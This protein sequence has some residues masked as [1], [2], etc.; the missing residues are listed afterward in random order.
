MKRIWRWLIGILF[1]LLIL[2][3]IAPFLFKDRIQQIVIDTANAN[4]N[5]D[6]YVE[7]I[8]LSFLS[9]FPNAHVSLENYRI[10][11]VAPFEKD[12]LM[13]GRQL[14]LVVNV[15]SVVRGESIEIKKIVVKAPRV[16][17]IMLADGTANWDIALADSSAVDTTTTEG[18]EYRLDLKSYEIQNAYIKYDDELLPMQM[19]IVDLTHSGGGAVTTSEYDLDTR[20]LIDKITVDY[21]GVAYLSQA[22]IE[23]D[24]DMH[25]VMGDEI[26]V[27][28]MDN[29]IKVNDLSLRADGE[30]AVGEE[31]IR[32]NLTYGA[33]EEA[34][35]KSIYSLI[36]GVYTEEYQEVDAEGDLTFEGSVNGVYNESQIPGFSLDLQVEDGQIQYPD[37][38]EAISAIQMDLHVQNPDG[39]LEKTEINLNNFQANIGADPI[40]ANAMIKGLENIFVK[41]EMEGTLDL[42][43]LAQALPLEGNELRGILTVD[44]QADG[45]YNEAKQQFPQVDAKMNMKDGYVKSADYPEAEITALNFDA[46]LSDASGSMAEAAFDMPAFSF[47]LAGE[48]MRGALRV[49]NFDN[50]KYNLSATG[51]LDL[52]KLMQI[53]PIEGMDLSGILVV[54]DFS[55]SGQLSDVEAERYDRLPTSGNVQIQNLRYASSDLPQPVNIS[56]GDAKFSPDRIDVDNMEIKTGSSDMRVNGFVENYLSYVLAD[57]PNI[58]GTW[59]ISG[60]RLD[61]NELMVTEEGDD[62]N[63]E[64]S[65]DSGSTYGVVP[66]PKGV[67]MLIQADMQEV[68]YR[69]LNLRNMSGIVEIIDQQVIMDNVKFG[70][71]GGNVAMRGSY[72]TQN[73]EKPAFAFDLDVDRLGFSDAVQNLVLVDRFAP[74]A[75]LIE[76]FFNTQLNIKGY[77]N[78]NMFPVLENIDSEG[79]FEI[80]EGRI[81][82]LPMM[83]KIAEKTKLQNLSKLTLDRLKGQFSIQDG[84]VVLSPIKIK[85]NDLELMIAGS[86]NITG[87][88]NYGVNLKVPS[89]KAGKAVFTALSD[90]LGGAVTP[91]DTLSFMVDVGGTL[92][93]PQIQGFESQTA[94]VV[95]DQLVKKAGDELADR[96]GVDVPLN[97]DSLDN[98]IAK[99]KERGQDSLQSMLDEQKEVVQDS[100]SKLAEEKKEDIKEEIDEVIEDKIGKEGKD[101]LNDLKNKLGLPI[102]SNKQNKDN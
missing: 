13:Q 62:V 65:S 44:A 85:Q 8:G 26:Q 96:I 27:Q 60:N 99:S 28:L 56:K 45:Y 79:I 88:M 33:T 91:Q 49:E 19:E 94:D 84:A 75:R 31:D 97:K 37:L 43:R 3:S 69:N 2:L 36:P 35:I 61:I 14:D 70:M 17:A 57:E 23:A 101:R 78:E 29:R 16:H 58:K 92:K 39:D 1:L 95:K 98:V 34:T 51:K 64:V 59:M 46:T 21:Q 22:N 20:T 89:G 63:Q 93:N 82:E 100:L 24:I 4:I 80:L 18:D 10:I 73:I 81:A 40:K 77:L 50:P 72:S 48:P 55:T 5:G 54:N 66:I 38:P 90:A 47:N 12:T 83:G 67:D 68:R 11:G 30:V 25:V 6:F 76:G 42:G 7:D 86:Q 32:L 15:L 41:G 74:V 87:Q 102:K 53:Y 52:E 71:L 9:R